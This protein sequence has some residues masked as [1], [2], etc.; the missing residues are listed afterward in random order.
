MN[1]QNTGKL[2]KRLSPNQVWIPI[3]IGLAVTIYLFV[4]NYNLEQILDLISRASLPWILASIGVLVARDVGYIYRLRYLS[5][6]E[7][8]WKSCFYSIVLWEFSSS[9]TPSAVGGSAL[10][11]FI[12]YKEGLKF[13]KSLA[14]VMLTAVLDNSFFLVFS[15]FALIFF[16]GMIFPDIGSLGDRIGASLPIFFYLS[17][18]LISVYTLVMIYGLLIRPRAL[19]WLLMV[20]TKPRIFRRY[21]KAAYEQGDEI[22]LASKELKGKDI[23]YW[24]RAISSTIFVWTSRYFML[25]CLIAAFSDINFMD[26]VIVLLRH[27]VMWVVMLI[28]FTPGAAGL[29]EI[30]F[31]GFFT[32]FMGNDTTAVGIFWRMF[33]FY[34]YLLLGALFLPRWFKRV[35][36]KDELKG[37]PNPVNT[38]KSKEEEFTER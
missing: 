12:L 6:K 23:T 32:D 38:F 15:L 30:A 24:V 19:K 2:T 18:G 28:S 25:N 22:I 9:I 27:L 1:Q 33:T 3:G 4:T 11:T 29:A 14:Y 34:P 20:V 16:P 5:N 37:I 10:A 17:F 36:S 21:R 13:G 7:L 35:F 8:S 31:K 26:H